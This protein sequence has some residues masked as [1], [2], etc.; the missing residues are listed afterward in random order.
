MV[1]RIPEVMHGDWE[2]SLWPKAVVT[3]DRNTYKFLAPNS[4]F[5][6]DVVLGKPDSRLGTW[7]GYQE[8]ALNYIWIYGVICEIFD[9]IIL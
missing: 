3:Y 2:C 4:A 1:N 7:Y 8:A 9:A 5:K 6:F